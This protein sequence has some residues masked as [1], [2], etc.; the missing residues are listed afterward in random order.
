[1]INNC[2][3]MTRLFLLNDPKSYSLNIVLL[4][5][6]ISPIWAFSPT[7]D[8]INDAT[9][10]INKTAKLEDRPLIKTF[11]INGTNPYKHILSDVEAELASESYSR[12]NSII[13]Y[14][15]INISSSIFH[16]PYN[17]Y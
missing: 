12:I 10:S 9:E 8:H 3:I 17:C 2:C 13:R 5:S 4:L 7:L 16:F 6:I 15:V 11:T 1:M 14:V